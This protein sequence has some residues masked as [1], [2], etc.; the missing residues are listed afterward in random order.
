MVE[1]RKTGGDGGEGKERATYNT[2][3]PPAEPAAGRKR[4][5]RPEGRNIWL[6]TE[7]RIQSRILRVQKLEEEGT[8]RPHRGPQLRSL[9]WG[10]MS[11]TRG[12]IGPPGVH[13]RTCAPVVAGSIWRLPASKH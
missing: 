1:E 13:P 4:A 10:G 9:A 12:K 7:E 8:E 2:P 6:K 5:N 3:A 11:P